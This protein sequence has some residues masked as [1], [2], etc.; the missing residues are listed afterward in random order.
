MLPGPA[1]LGGPSAPFQLYEPGR[2]EVLPGIRPGGFVS[3]ESF[4]SP[5]FKN[6]RQLTLA[7]RGADRSAKCHGGPRCREKI[8]S[9][10]GPCAVVQTKY[11]EGHAPSW[12]RITMDHQPARRRTRRRASLHFDLGRPSI[13]EGHAPSWPH[14]TRRGRCCACPCAK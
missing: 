14:A 2:G 10:G 12:P 4:V 5:S 11:L 8:S 6:H 7:A 9:F 13:L 1:L 3:T